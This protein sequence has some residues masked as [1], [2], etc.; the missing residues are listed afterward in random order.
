MST[1]TFAIVAASLGIAACGGSTSPGYLMSTSP[2]PVA[3]NTIIAGADITFNPATLAVSKGTSVAFV[4]EG[5]AH[6]VYFVGAGKPA[7]IP[8]ASNTTAS[9]TF[10]NAGSFG[11]RCSIHPQMAATITVQ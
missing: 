5:V 6:Q 11:V 1:R 9:R 3:P 10:A 8:I 4:F 2:P 7:D